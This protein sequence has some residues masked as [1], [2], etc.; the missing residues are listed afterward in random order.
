MIYDLISTKYI[1]YENINTKIKF[2]NNIDKKILFGSELIN[3]LKKI[4]NKINYIL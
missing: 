2:K 4:K 3:F 1:I